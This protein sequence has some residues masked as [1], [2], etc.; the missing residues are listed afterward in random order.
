MNSILHLSRLAVKPYGRFALLLLVLGMASC[1]RVDPVI[2]IGFVAPFEGRNR[3][4]GYDTIYSARLATREINEAGGINGYDIELVALDDGGDLRQAFE[5]AE[6]LL[7]DP[8]VMLVVGHW[9]PEINA[10]VADLY[11]TGEIGFIATGSGL[12]QSYPA[13]NL[14]LSFRQR[15]E[16]ATPFEEVAGPY[17]GPAYDSMLLAFA[18]IDSATEAADPNRA[19]IREALARQT[20]EGVTGTIN[21]SGGP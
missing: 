2:K 6:S 11:A 1:Q 13:E 3:E 14:P 5:V 19:T 21:W 10:M 16:A 7:I 9:H 8:D 18:A 15:Y 4:V 17:A 12:I 20:I